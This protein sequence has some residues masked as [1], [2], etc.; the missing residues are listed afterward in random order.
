MCVGVGAG[1]EPYLTCE[2]QPLDISHE[3]EHFQTSCACVKS[4]VSL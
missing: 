2:K 4:D 3:S 1:G